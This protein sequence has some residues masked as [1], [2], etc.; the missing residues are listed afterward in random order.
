LAKKD[1]DLT[2]EKQLKKDS[3]AAHAQLIATKNAEIQS[4]VKDLAAVK[5]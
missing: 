5:K 4:L 3:D 1:S 2:R